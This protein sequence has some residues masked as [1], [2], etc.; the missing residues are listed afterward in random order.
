MGRVSRAATAACLLVCLAHGADSRPSYATRIPNGVSVPAPDGSGAI[1]NGVGHNTCYGGGPRNPFGQAFE[2]A[3]LQWTVE[4]C[5]ADSDGDGL[6]N[7]Q[8]L[9]DPCCAWTPGASP[10]QNAALSHPG[11]AES[12]ADITAQASINCTEQPAESAFH[13]FS[14]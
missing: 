7:G 11:F 13:Q 2:A 10:L 3:S 1:C 12:V 5:Q 4:L 8:E 6:T 14:W 9:G